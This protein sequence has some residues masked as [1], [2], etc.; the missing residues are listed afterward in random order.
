MNKNQLV[1]YSKK[2]RLTFLQKM[3][4]YMWLLFDKV[5]DESR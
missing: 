3:K 4:Y 1:V 2:I 5:D